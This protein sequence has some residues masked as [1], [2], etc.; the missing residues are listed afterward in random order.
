MVVK[1]IHV[2][3]DQHHPVY[4]RGKPEIVKEFPDIGWQAP[5]MPVLAD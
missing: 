3:A 1:R 4:L 2:G 5:V